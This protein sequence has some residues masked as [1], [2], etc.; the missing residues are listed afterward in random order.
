VLNFLTK[1][2][3]LFE[4]ENLDKIGMENL[5]T[6]EEHITEEY[7]E[8]ENRIEEG[9][10]I[11]PHNIW[12]KYLLELEEDDE[13]KFWKDIEER[14]NSDPNLRER[15]YSGL[16]AII[17]IIAETKLGSHEKGLPKE[18]I[19]KIIDFTDKFYEMSEKFYSDISPDSEK[20]GKILLE[21]RGF[22][23]DNNIPEKYLTIENLLK[24]HYWR[25]KYF[26][27][28]FKDMKQKEIKKEDLMNFMPGLRKIFRD[29]PDKIEKWLNYW[30]GQGDLFETKH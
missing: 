26:E 27:E 9:G 7:L 8:I 1:F 28:V 20:Q 24:L 2:S 18:D 23:K 16:S 21:L 30:S 25:E 11:L 5:E 14:I 22:F 3:A 29:N 15:L 6:K 12:E 13:D 10:K 17:E 19:D 4:L